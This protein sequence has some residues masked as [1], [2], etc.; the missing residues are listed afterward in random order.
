[1]SKT[2]RKP[3]G[4]P[5]REEAEILLSAFSVESTGLR[6]GEV[7]SGRTNVTKGAMFEY[8]APLG[9]SEGYTLT[10][11]KSMV[12]SVY[13]SN[14]ATREQIEGRVVRMGQTAK[15]VDFVMVHTGILTYI[16]QRHIDARNLA[17]V[18]AKLADEI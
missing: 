11:L 1:M 3:A 13:P 7:A 16:M 2:P 18:L 17:A 8:R 10:R 9:K 14:N 6:P 4:N 5:N 12:T 15:S